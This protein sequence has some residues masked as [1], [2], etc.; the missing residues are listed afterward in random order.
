MPESHDERLRIDDRLLVET[1]HRIN[2]V[3]AGDLLAPVYC[4]R[5]PPTDEQVIASIVGE[6]V[7][8]FF[9]DRVA[10]WQGPGYLVRFFQK[11]MTRSNFHAAVLHEVAHAFQNVLP[12][13]YLLPEPM[14]T[15]ERK[16]LVTQRNPSSSYDNYKGH[17]PDFW[18]ICLHTWSRGVDAGFPCEPRQLGLTWVDTDL[19]LE[20]LRPEIESEW[21]TPLWKIGLRPVPRH[22]DT[23]FDF[24]PN[25][26]DK[27]DLSPLNPHSDGL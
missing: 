18:R 7:S 9:R 16:Q 24:D 26:W 10:D 11:E 12:W 21:N 8:C 13:P 23:L 25:D 6:D 5:E 22:F 17:R 19:M 3:F 4:I 1:Q 2:D 20:T 27:L 14:H 15:E